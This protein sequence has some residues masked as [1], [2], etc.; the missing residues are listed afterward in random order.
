MVV[1]QGGAVSCATAALTGLA[2]RL[3]SLVEQLVA[4]YNISEQELEVRH[5]SDIATFLYAFACFT[6]FHNSS[7]NINYM[8][9][10]YK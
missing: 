5:Y 1:Q 9:I 4:S 6:C 3:N 8:F 2:S 10:K 7:T